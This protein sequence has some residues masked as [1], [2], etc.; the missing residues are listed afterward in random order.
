M[1]TD[2]AFF[3]D[4]SVHDWRNFFTSIFIFVWT[5]IVF[6]GDKV[7]REASNTLDG[8]MLARNHTVRGVSSSRGA[9]VLSLP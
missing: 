5:V 9:R 4:I 6:L 1:Q 7:T 2:Y 3:K 8:K